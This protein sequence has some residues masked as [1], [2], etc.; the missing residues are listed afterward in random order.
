MAG[1]AMLSGISVCLPAN[2]NMTGTMFEQPTPT[3]A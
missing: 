1:T 3:S 2:E